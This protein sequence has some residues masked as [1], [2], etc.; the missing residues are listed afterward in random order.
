MAPVNVTFETSRVSKILRAIDDGFMAIPPRE[1]EPGSEWTLAHKQ[2]FIDTLRHDKPLPRILLR[3]VSKYE[4]PVL[5]VGYSWIRVLDEFVH[6]A[7]SINRLYFSDLRP[8]EQRL[9]MRMDIR[10]IV[11][12]DPEATEEEARAAFDDITSEDDREDEL[13]ASPPS[14]LQV[15][16]RIRAARDAISGLRAQPDEPRLSLYDVYAAM[17]LAVDAL[18]HLPREAAWADMVALMDKWLLSH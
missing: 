7:F 4:S 10:A 15:A 1:L 18:D 3:K 13:P 17:S 2:Q 9:F 16:A 5:Q 14:T 11:C 8:E 12:D 6:D